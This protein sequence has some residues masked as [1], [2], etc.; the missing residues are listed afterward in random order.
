MHGQILAALPGIL[1]HGGL[2]DVGHLFNNIE[3][4]QP[5][6]ARSGIRQC[7]EACVVFLAHVLHMAQPV[8]AQADAVAA[9]CSTDA[10][11]SV[12]TDNDDV[13]DLQHIHRELDH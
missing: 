8:V 12:V 4:A 1:H 7:R 3:F 9:Q 2:T 13:S 10:A 6:A 5:V 11:A